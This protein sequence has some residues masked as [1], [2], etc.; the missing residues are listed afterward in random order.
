MELTLQV[1]I[2]K[3]GPFCLCFTALFLFGS[4]DEFFPFIFVTV[5]LR[6]HEQ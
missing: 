2:T 6:L 1:P 5:R 3:E 4:V